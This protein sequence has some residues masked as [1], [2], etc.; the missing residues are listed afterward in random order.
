MVVE[1]PA[2]AN[3]DASFEFGV[4]ER[5]LSLS[6]RPL[7]FVDYR[8]PTLVTDDGERVGGVWTRVVHAEL[9]GSRVYIS[10][11]KMSALY[12]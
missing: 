6:K 12:V 10:P 5:V 11:E 1:V 2:V 8:H 9:F 3:A 7:E 4:S